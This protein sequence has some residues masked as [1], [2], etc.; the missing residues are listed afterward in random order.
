M[1]QPDFWHDADA[2][3]EVINEVNTLKTWSEPWRRLT[4]R[5]R[6]L[7]ELAELL[8]AERDEAMAEEWSNEVE[9]TGRALAAFELR[10]MLQGPDD[11]R[12]ALLTIHPGAGGTESQDW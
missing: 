7:Q 11:M 5:V 9:A 10:N 12:D 2:A 8:Q 6:D 4:A 1:A 3:R